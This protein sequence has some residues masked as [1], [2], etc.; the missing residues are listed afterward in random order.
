[1]KNVKGGKKTMLKPQPQIEVFTSFCPFPMPF[2]F[3]DEYI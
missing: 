3:H 2:Y 1:M